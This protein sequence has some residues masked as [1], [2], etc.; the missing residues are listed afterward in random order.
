MSYELWVK[1]VTHSNPLVI[2][3]ILH[4]AYNQRELQINDT[5]QP[6]FHPATPLAW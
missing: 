1:K 6:G 3:E 2:Q 4:H 5:N